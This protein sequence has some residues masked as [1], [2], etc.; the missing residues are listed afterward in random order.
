MNMKV[1]NI[2]CL[3]ITIL[4]GAS[5]SANNVRIENFSK[6]GNKV[7]FDLKWDNSWSYTSGGQVH[8]DAVYLFVKQ[9]P[10]GG[11]SWVHANI[12]TATAT[13]NY[14]A[15]IPANNL[16]T[17]VYHNIQNVNAST[18]ISLTLSGLIGA[19]QD[20][21]V[22]AIEMVKIPTGPFRLGDGASDRTYHRGDDPTKSYPV[23]GEGLITR[24]S[25]SS[26]FDGG[27]SGYAGDIAAAFPKGYDGFYCMKY[28]LTQQ[29]YVDF[30]N[31]L[32]RHAQDLR[33]FSDLSGTTV[34][35]NFVMSNT[36]NPSF[37]HG[38]SCDNNIGTGNITF[39]CDLDND[40]IGNETNDGQNKIAG[41]FTIADVYAYLDWA[42]LGPMTSLQY[43]KAC[44]GPL[45]AVPLEFAWG[46]TLENSAGTILNEGTIQEKF[47]NSGIDGGIFALLDAQRV[48]LNAPTSN[49][50]RELSN[51]SYYGVIGLSGTANNPV[52]SIAEIYSGA[53][54]NGQL[55]SAGEADF[56]DITIPLQVKAG[57]PDISG[58]KGRVSS[59]NA[60][61]TATS[62]R[63]SKRNSGIRGIW[64]L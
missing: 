32:P 25:S 6:T 27:S 1:K 47:S 61:N 7:T 57:V 41:F 20:I 60:I 63:D 23:T 16:A 30:L 44:R 59:Y 31:C 4:Y 55:T 15:D 43:E 52:V 64:K 8:H 2:I 50:T 24:G 46:S 9:A 26:D 29:Q 48:G 5:L 28:L 37:G 18:T 21:K 53:Q 3:L 45:Q 22:M 54:G 10:N 36:S 17:M 58:T 34:T 11:P 35:N 62:P 13:N 40:G 38:I 56:F 42:G 19:Y 14:T 12:S 39:Y 33:T 51:A 49:A